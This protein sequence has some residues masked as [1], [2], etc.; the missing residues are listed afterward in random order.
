MTA[1]SLA[2]TVAPY[3]SAASHLFDYLER[4]SW[5]LGD[6]ETLP[7]EAVIARD[8]QIAAR[9]AAS[10]V[11]LPLLGLKTRANLDLPSTHVL[12]MAALP[13]LDV[14]LGDQLDDRI[15]GTTATVQELISLLAFS[16]E[17]EAALL[18]VFAPDAPLRAFGLIELGDGRKP[19]LHRSVHVDD[20]MIAF[21]RG[22]ASL[23]PGLADVA[24]LERGAPATVDAVAVDT[25]R[26]LLDSAGPIIVEGAARTGKTVAVI[27]AIASRG[28]PVLVADLELVI[29][30]PKPHEVLDRL[31]REAI[32]H[33][34]AFVLRAAEVELTPAVMR[35]VC[36]FVQDG[37]AIVTVR[38]GDP[39]ARALRGPRRVRVATP[40]A[41]DQQRIWR[42]GI[43]AVSAAAV[44]ERYPLPPGE[45]VLAAAAARAQREVERRPIRED[46]LFAAA[47]GRLCH[48]LGDVAEL[49]ST[50][51]TWDDLV[52]R[53]EVTTRILEIVAA[54]RFRDQVMN[55]WGFSAK[56]PY[57]RSLS[58]LFSGPPGTG[59]TM[60]ATLIGKELGLE[61]FRVDLSKVVSKYIGETEKN[62]GRVFEEASRCHGVILFDEA[63]SLFAKRTEVKSSNDRYAN[64]EVN[65]LLQRL[66]AHDGIVILTTNAATAID[67]AFMR[68]LRYRIEFPEPDE[69]EREG[70]WHAMVP[71]AAPLA[72]DVD[73]A[74]L[75]RKFRLT[76][77]HI[78][79]AVVRAAYLAAADGQT[80]IT[81]D[82]LVRAATLEWME[83]GR[84][85]GA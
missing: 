42:Q 43:P 57:G 48:R 68:R 52:L 9:E 24:A 26:S 5:V 78:K 19:L 29:A 53:E 71:K 3:S 32:L 17:D 49:V 64:L 85:P 41:A 36:R 76:G 27:A 67:P 55:D 54:V 65:F 44:C 35:Q 60:V 74:A 79:N 82:S 10:T 1:Q 13:G 28:Q 39:I 18:P 12:V 31:R 8:E 59:K 2:S 45:I 62:L 40:S 15:A 66:E 33:G 80:T 46:D 30:D 20:R 70:L 23:D 6:R 73:F 11:T 16:E 51:L 14:L 58:A 56:L 75:G 63:D 37:A 34:G 61:V 84:L 83:L 38:N 4:A 81:H 77:G 21:L 25:I 7:V 69:T 47:R 50:T 22:D 72:P